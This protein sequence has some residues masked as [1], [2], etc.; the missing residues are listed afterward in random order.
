M[1]R[2]GL[3]DAAL[4]F[5]VN[6]MDNGIIDANLGGKVF[7]KRIPSPGRGKSGGARTLIAYKNSERAFFMFGFSKNERANI[8][9]NE[10]KAL[11]LMAR[12][13]L[14]KSDAMLKRDL[15]EKILIEVR[16]NG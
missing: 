4:I 3:K 16:T 5:A 9:A 12:V 7:K 6:E 8:D 10:L 11:K 13:L 14:E 2:E 15:E 1:R